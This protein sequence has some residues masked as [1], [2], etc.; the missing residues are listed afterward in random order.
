MKGEW[1]DGD[2]VLR[3]GA[4][5][6]SFKL[7]GRKLESGNVFGTIMEERTMHPV[8]VLPLPDMERLAHAILTIAKDYKEGIR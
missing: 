7:S 5:R 2:Y 3:G 1:V 8:L 6:L 4:N